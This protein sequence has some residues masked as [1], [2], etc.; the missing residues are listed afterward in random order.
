MMVRWAGEFSKTHPG[1]R[2]DVSA[3]GAGKGIADAIAGLVDIGMVS[4]D[5]RPEESQRGARYVP[6][7]KDAVFP[8]MNAKNPALQKVMSRGL[9]KKQ[10]VALWIEGKDISWGKLT[11]STVDGSVRV[12]TRSD[13][14]GA[15]ETWAAYLGKHQEDLK[16][17]GVYGDPG[18]AEAV[19]KDALGV[20]FNN[21]NYA[22]DAITGLPARGLQVLPI[23][24]NENGTVS[25]THLTL[26]T[27]RIV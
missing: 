26:P 2:I 10:F 27:K 9:T 19:G 16:G 23:D 13:A 18:M 1:W 17:V 7:V 12:Y 11:G 3:G 15:A 8:V 21:L 22:Y 20:G 6:V 25:Y 4:R 24:V 14:C 5:I